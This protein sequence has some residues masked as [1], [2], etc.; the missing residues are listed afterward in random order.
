MAYT[1]GGCLVTC[2]MTQ[3]GLDYR[4]SI[5]FENRLLTLRTIH[6]FYNWFKI[7]LWTWVFVV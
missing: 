2:I 6:S 3:D 4:L 5:K 7:I 1:R